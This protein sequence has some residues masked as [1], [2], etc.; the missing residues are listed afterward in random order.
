MVACA[1]PTNSPKYASWD[2][3]LLVDANARVGTYPST[4]VG[5]WQAEADTDKSEYFLQF[6]HAN[7][8][9][10]PATFENFQTGEGG[11]WR[12]SNGKWLRNDF[13]GLPLAWQPHS[14]RAFC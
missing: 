12:H 7:Q 8:I 11:T 9:R 2:R 13:I 4:N 5:S 14:L 1:C 3:V 6:L 10:L